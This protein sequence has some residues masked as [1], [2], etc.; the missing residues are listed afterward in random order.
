MRNKIVEPTTAISISINLSIAYY[1]KP[2]EGAIVVLSM[3]LYNLSG[4]GGFIKIN[5]IAIGMILMHKNCI[6]LVN[7]WCTVFLSEFHFI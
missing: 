3:E 7:K 1:R 6:N 5:K 2:G 4:C